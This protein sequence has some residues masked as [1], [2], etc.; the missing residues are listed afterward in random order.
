[1]KTFEQVTANSIRR[2]RPEPDAGPPP[3]ARQVGAPATARQC[4]PRRR[5]KQKLL[6]SRK[7]HALP[8]AVVR[9]SPAGGGTERTRCG[10][11]RR[12]P[13]WPVPNGCGDIGVLAEAIDSG[14][15]HRSDFAQASSSLASSGRAARSELGSFGDDYPWLRG[16][17][18]TM[19][20]LGS[21]SSNV[22]FWKGLQDS[23][24]RFAR[25]LVSAWCCS[26]SRVDGGIRRRMAAQSRTSFSRQLLT[27]ASALARAAAGRRAT[28]T[29]G[30]WGSCRWRSAIGTILESRVRVET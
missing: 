17:V 23:A 9:F 5:R 14:R 30:R 13:A 11:R 26:Q 8:Q 28:A 19:T 20:C 22:R 6:P 25:R 12:H 1:M 29:R 3:P 7:S 27:V 21:A 4:S 16:V 18:K 2:A 10:R 15:P 24:D